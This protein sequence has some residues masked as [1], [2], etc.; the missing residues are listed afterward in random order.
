MKYIN[1][2]HADKSWVN[3]DHDRANLVP[4]AVR[5]TARSFVPTYPQTVDTTLIPA[6]RG[7][8]CQGFWPRRATLA[9]S[10][11]GPHA[12]PQPSERPEDVS[13]QDQERLEQALCL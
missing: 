11:V 3:Q 7:F 13:T 4:G 9:T 1:R 12:G 2:D 8:W 6:F 5:V 10:S